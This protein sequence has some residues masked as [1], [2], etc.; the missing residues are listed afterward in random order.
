M[1]GD[2]VNI[3]HYFN[4]AQKVTSDHAPAI[5]TGAGSV[6]LVGTAVLTGVGAFKAAKVLAEDDRNR[7]IFEQANPGTIQPRTKVDAAKLTWKFYVPAAGVGI[8]S[9]ACIIMS[10]RI[11][12][13]RLAA[14][15][16]AYAISEKAYS[17]YK[18]KV[19]Q[20]VGKN[21]ERKVRDEIAQ[22]RV[23][24]DNHENRVVYSAIDGG[25]HLCYEQYTGHYTQSSMEG[26]NSIRNELNDTLL[27]TD[28]ISLSEWYQKLGIP[29]TEFSDSVGWRSDGGLVELDVTSTLSE[30]VPCLAFNFLPSPKPGFDGSH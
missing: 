13:K 27:R 20:H 28:Y 11:N 16:A 23:N 18:E 12:S 6:G 15:G 30:G 1:Q 22:D 8:G 17:E 14:M 5:L 21:K 4:V 3:R 9:V 19:E 25:L 7:E 2:A 10:N 29:T 24:K 26:L